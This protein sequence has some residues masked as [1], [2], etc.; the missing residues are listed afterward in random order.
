MECQHACE[1]FLFARAGAGTTESTQRVCR[2][3]ELGERAPREHLILIYAHA[4]AA[5]G[6]YAMLQSIEQRVAARDPLGAL[7]GL[8]GERLTASDV[9]RHADAKLGGCRSCGGRRLTF[10]VRRH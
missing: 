4:G 1:L 8:F 7:I 6:N 2:R 10:E 5:R 9:P 3:R